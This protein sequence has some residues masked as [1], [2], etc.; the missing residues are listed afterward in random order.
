MSRDN[1]NLRYCLGLN[2]QQIFKFEKNN[3]KTWVAVLGVRFYGLEPNLLLLQCQLW[4]YLE[5][6][7]KAKANIIIQNKKGGNDEN[8]RNVRRE[9]MIIAL[10]VLWIDKLSIIIEKKMCPAMSRLELSVLIKI[11][12]KAS[13]LQSSP[14]I[15]IVL[16]LAL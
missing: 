10:A 8:E 6:T 12:I 15:R 13:L 1:N 11:Q 7:W 16:H 3:R 4:K 2:H 5:R 9:I 14:V